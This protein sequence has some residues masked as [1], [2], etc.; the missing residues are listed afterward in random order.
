MRK[1]AESNLLIGNI[2]VNIY[3]DDFC[4]CTSMNVKMV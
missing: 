2:Y 1:A 3:G 4:I